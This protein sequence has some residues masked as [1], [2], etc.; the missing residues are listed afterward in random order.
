VSS[1]ASL[2]GSS[3]DGCGG[4]T[5]GNASGFAHQRAGRQNRTS[6]FTL[7]LSS[8]RRADRRHI[9]RSRDMQIQLPTSTNDSDET[10]HTFHHNASSDVLH[11]HVFP[12]SSAATRQ[13]PLVPAPTLQDS[14]R[15]TN[16]WGLAL[17]RLRNLELEPRHRPHSAG[18]GPHRTRT[19]LGLRCCRRV[20]IGITARVAHAGSWLML[21][22]DRADIV[23]SPPRACNV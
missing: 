17:H 22:N 18:G 21:N 13:P 12:R 8:H 2:K 19:T 7:Q 11:C 5:D 16:R 15:R 4:A 10:R 9:N 23:P 14:S 6:E 1:G 3:R 20:A